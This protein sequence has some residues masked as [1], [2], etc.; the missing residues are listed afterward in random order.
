MQTATQLQWSVEGN[1]FYS[2]KSVYFATSATIA[3]I[4]SDSQLEPAFGPPV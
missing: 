4:R 1:Q 3:G 2:R